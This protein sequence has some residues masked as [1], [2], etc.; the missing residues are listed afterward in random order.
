MTV[1]A[2]LTRMAGLAVA[3]YG[4]LHFAPGAT[5]SR[6]IR[7]RFFPG[8]AGFGSSNTVAI[9][10][11][12][13]PDPDSTPQILDEL[14]RLKLSATFFLLGSMVSAAPTLASEIVERGHEVGLHGDV[15]KSHLL[16]N[17]NDVRADVQRAYELVVNAAGVRPAFFRPPYGAISG[18]SLLA[19]RQL[20]MRTVLWSAWGRDWRSEA[21]AQTVMEDLH[22]DIRGGATI[23]LHD[24]DCTSAPCS[25][26]S[27]L[28]ALP[29]LADEL[30]TQ[31]LR[32][33]SLTQH[34]S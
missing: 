6:P 31:G 1:A 32:A 11:D 9:T 21:T 17:H 8:L 27:T 25:W 26:K 34:L 20:R 33:V 14:E 28:G 23:L 16:R 24:S 3:G 15:H 22:P 12:D 2:G 19:A 13:G 30:T 7:H 4:V 29:L 10:F 5:T 18:G